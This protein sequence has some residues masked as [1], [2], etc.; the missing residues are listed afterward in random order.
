M[1]YTSQSL[2]LAFLILGLITF[3]YRYSF[4]SSVGQKVSNRIPREFLQFLA[5]ATFTS[6]IVNNILAYRSDGTNFKK[7]LIVAVLSAGVAYK[8][9]NIIATLLFGLGL[10]YIL[11]NFITL[12]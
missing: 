7:I 11:Q 9:K 6:I 10:L 4:I 12:V 3:L 8:T 5:P 1:N 2:L